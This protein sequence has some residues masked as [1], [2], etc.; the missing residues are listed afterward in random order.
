MIVLFYDPGA[1]R[2]GYAVIAGDGK[3]EPRYIDSGI[4][5]CPRYDD[6][7]FQD[8][9]LRLEEFWTYK[10]PELLEIYK[11]DV[12]ANEVVPAVGGGS[13]IVATQSELVKAAITVVHAMAFER[14]KPVA[15]ISAITIKSKI[16][17]KKTATKV[18]VRNGVIDLLPELATKKK[19]WTKVFDESDALA[20]GLAF[21]GYTNF[22]K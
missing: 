16:G 15:Q 18:A 11:P 13:F 1:E 17:K 6:E 14:D 8:Y 9:K 22:R 19:G 2:M 10:G 3:T 5:K 20:G 12:V 4:I 21:L 7:G